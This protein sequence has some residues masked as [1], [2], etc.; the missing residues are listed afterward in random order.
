MSFFLAFASQIIP[1]NLSINGHPKFK[2]TKITTTK[3]TALSDL[4]NQLEKDG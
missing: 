1:L 3:D 2:H 4:H